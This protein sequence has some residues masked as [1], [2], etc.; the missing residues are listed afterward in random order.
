MKNLFLC[1]AFF[2]L[3]TH[4]IAQDK[5]VPAFEEVLS[6]NSVGTPIISPDGQHLVYTVRSADWASNG[7]DTEIWLRRAGEVPFQLTNTRDGSSSNPQWSPDGEWVSF[8][9]KR[10]ENSQVH[11]IRINGGEAVQLT[12][13]DESIGNYAWS[14]DGTRIAFT[15]A[16]GDEEQEKERT[17]RF[18]AYEVDEADFK[19][20]WLY[21]VEVDPDHPKPSSLPCYGAQDSTAQDWDCIEWPQAEALL[22]SVPFTIRNFAWSP[23]GQHIA[24]THTPDPLINSF[25]DADISILDVATGEH[26]VVVDNASTTPLKIGRPTASRSSTAPMSTTAPPTTIPTAAY[27]AS[28]WTVVPPKSWPPI[29]TRT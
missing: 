22:D 23:D 27:F 4:L 28:R 18:G 16:V 29:S 3:T 17:D 2:G 1:L 15:R 21:V 6:L 26:R 10:G 11:A 24:F 7:Y 12:H 14:P 19:L 8:I 9:A 5:H 25:F 13:E 20:N